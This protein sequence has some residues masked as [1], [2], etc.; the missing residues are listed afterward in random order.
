MGLLENILGIWPPEIPDPPI[1]TSVLPAVAI[2]DIR[3][4]K[5]PKL[6]VSNISLGNGEICHYID[7]ACLVTKKIEKHYHRRNNGMSFKIAKGMY[8]HTGDSNGHPIEYE[9]PIYTKGYLCITNKRVVFVSKEKGFDKKIK[10]ISSITPYTDAIG[11]QFGEKIFNVL[12]PSS[13]IAN[14]VLN[15][16][17]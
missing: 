9:I 1:M 15:L 17:K 12:L 13:D 3:A 14:M 4:G 10:A 6:N 11:L 7:E 8:Y 2:N 5:L 16:L